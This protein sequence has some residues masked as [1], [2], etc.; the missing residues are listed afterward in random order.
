MNSRKE[1]R[2]ASADIHIPTQMKIGKK[3]KGTTSD[4]PRAFD[5]E[6]PFS[7]KFFDKDAH[8]LFEQT[9]VG[10]NINVEVLFTHTKLE[11]SEFLKYLAD[12]NL[13][14]WATKFTKFSRE[15]VYEFY[16]N[17]TQEV[18]HTGS[19]WDR[20]VYFR[21]SRIDITPALLNALVEVNPVTNGL[22]PDDLVKKSDSEIANHL[23]AGRVRTFEKKVKVNHLTPTFQ[24]LYKFVAKNV[25]PI[26]N[27]SEIALEVGK[28]LYAIDRHTM[29]SWTMVSLYCRE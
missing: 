8:D 13:L 18:D 6:N 21:K 29:T 20:I 27:K 2:K 15:S 1:K 10:K 4:P 7:D 22:L 25:Y 9:I 19:Q 23:T 16:A 11:N 14:G 3:Q 17:L 12:R 5:F 28:I 26:S 24:W